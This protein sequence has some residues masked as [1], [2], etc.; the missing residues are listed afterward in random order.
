M[1]PL[2]N[3]EDRTRV[4][5]VSAALSQQVTSLPMGPWMTEAQIDQVAEALRAAPTSLLE[6]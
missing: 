1:K 5:P 3:S 2:M 4:F 6:L